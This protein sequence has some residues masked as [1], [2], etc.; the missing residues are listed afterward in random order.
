MNLLQANGEGAGQSVPHLHFH[1]MPRVA[2]DGVSLNWAYKPGDMAAIKAVYERL[3]AALLKG[4]RQA[5]R[6]RHAG[7]SSED[8]LEP[9]DQQDYSCGG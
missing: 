1:I 3:K 7:A 5:C 9:I 4:R 8:Q 2:G 6:D